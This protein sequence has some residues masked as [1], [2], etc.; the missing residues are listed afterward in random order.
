MHYNSITSAGGVRLYISNL[1]VFNVRNDLRLNL[2]RVKDLWIE[3]TV[4][5]KPYAVGVIYHHPT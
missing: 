5:N 3:I 1:L 4:N 2:D